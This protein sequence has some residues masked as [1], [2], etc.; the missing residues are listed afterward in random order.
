MLR[1]AAKA[2]T[3]KKLIVTSSVAA[4]ADEFKNGK[5]YNEEDWNSISS[6]TRSPYS[7][8]K[9]LAEKA[10]IKFVEDLEGG[11]GFELNRLR[12]LMVRETELD[13][14]GL[15]GKNNSAVDGRPFGT[16]PTILRRGL[17]CH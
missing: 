10:A 5:V 1:S 11:Q 15:A 12:P 16:L 17:S 9:V 7:Y 8:S 4:V 13:S 2:G 14:A 6:L 3:V